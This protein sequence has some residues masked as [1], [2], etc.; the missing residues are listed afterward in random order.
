MGTAIAD[1]IEGPYR[2]EGIFLRSGMWA[3]PSEDG[4]I[5]DALVH[6]NTLDPHAFVDASGHHQLVYGCYSGGIFLLELAPVTR[7]PLLGRGYGVCLRGGN[8]A[9]MESRFLLHS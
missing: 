6:P 1:H 8:R 3:E 2:D 5:Y 4:D 7:R 9:L